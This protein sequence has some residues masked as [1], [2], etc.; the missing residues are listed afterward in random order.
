MRQPSLKD[1]AARAGTST[2]VVSYVINDGPRP[3]AK[4]TKQR[5]EAAIAELEYSPNVLARGLR[6]Q[7]TNIIGLLVPDLSLP[8]FAEL[9]AAIDDAAVPAGQRVLVG[10]TR[11]DLGREAKQLKAL[12]ESRVDGLIVAPTG[13]QLPDLELLASRRV[14]TVIAHRDLRTYPLPEFADWQPS[15]VCT[16]DEAAGRQATEHLIDHGFQNLVCLA[17]PLDGTPVALRAE[18][19]RQAV[20]SRLGE[21]APFTLIESDYGNLIEDAYATTAELLASDPEVDGI[22]A[23]TDDQALGAMRAI[24]ESG[25]TLGRDVGL[26][27]IGGTRMTDHLAHPLTVLQTPLADFGQRCMSAALANTSSSHVLPMKLIAR[28]SCGCN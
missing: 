28:S 9:A 26:I 18:G 1:V 11:F 12:L 14:P 8:F 5:V 27:D 6:T 24:V 22:C 13:P 25:R 4:A 17:G 16:D 3:V 20:Q 7:R 15:F 10:A 21:R 23:T 19:F 2:A